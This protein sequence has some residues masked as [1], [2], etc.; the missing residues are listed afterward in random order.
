MLDKQWEKEIKKL[1]FFVTT[2]VKEQKTLDKC[3]TFYFV[4]IFCTSSTKVTY[5]DHEKK[6]STKNG[7]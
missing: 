6:H 3:S 5:F 2:S 1:H 4:Y 7:L